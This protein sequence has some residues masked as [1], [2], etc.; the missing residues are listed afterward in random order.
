VGDDISF[1]GTVSNDALGGIVTGV[2]ATV[3]TFGAAGD[4]AAETIGSYGVSVTSGQTKAAWMAEIE[5]EF[6]A[7][8]DSFRI[9]MSA[10]RGRVLSPF[11]G[12]WFRRPAAWAASLR[13]YQHD[14]HIAV[15]AKELGPVDFVLT[16]ED[17][18]L[19]E[20]DDRVDGEAG[21][22]ARFTTFRTWANGPQGAFLAFSCTRAVEGSL[23]GSTHNVA[24][25]NHAC[26]IVQLNAE[27]VI[28]RSLVLNDDGTAT[29][30]SLSTIKAEVN[31]ALML[32]LLQNAKGEG[33]RASKAVWTPSD[34]DI[35][36]VAE[37]TLTGV[38][39]LNLRGT[40]HRVNT[41]VRVISG[42]Q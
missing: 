6:E 18:N 25:T 36:N 30:D 2:T 7:V 1:E 35:L 14:L 8:D 28:G 9:D 39:E 33:Q 26:T 38:L 13:E 4:L 29:S 19:V 31:S 17:D 41:N 34:D 37:A 5:E 27:N 11:T 40:I 15:W 21:T 42:G 3:L 10:G 22:A 16:D 20:W 12:W 32:G 24:V 23:L